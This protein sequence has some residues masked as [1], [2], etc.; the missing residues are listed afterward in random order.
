MALK[1][2]YNPFT[3]KFDCV[4]GNPFDYIKFNLDA[5]YEVGTG[6]MAWNADEHTLEFGMDGGVV[7]Q[8]GHE[9]FY[10]ISVNQTGSDI[11]EGAFVQF[12]GTLGNSGKLLIAPRVSDGS[13]PV[14]FSMGVVTN[15]GGIADGD[16]GHVTWFG[17]VRGLDTTGTYLT[18][19]DSIDEVNF[20]T[21][22]DGS[23]LYPNPAWDGHFTI[24]RPNA[25]NDKSPIAAVIH[26]HT[27][28]TILVRPHLIPKF[29]DLSDVNGTPVVTTG[30]LPVW[31]QVGK[32]FDFNY[33]ILDYQLKDDFTE[34]SVLFRGA[35]E[36]DEDNSN[37]FWD[38]IN[39]R[40]GIGTNTPQQLFHTYKNTNGPNL[41]LFENPNIGVAAFAGM[42]LKTDGGSSYIYRTSDAYAGG[43]E[44]SLVI[45]DAGNGGG[46]VFFVGN[47]RMRIIP[48]GNIGINKSTLA[49][50]AQLDI[51]NRF[52]SQPGLRLK[53]AIS[54]SA[55]LQ[56]NIKSDDTLYSGI[57]NIGERFNFDNVKN[58]F[59]TG[60]DASFHY[61]GTDLIVDPKEVSTGILSVLGAIG[62]E[63]LSTDPVDPA[64]GKSVI[65]QSD[66]TTT[67]DDG[68]ILIKE[69]SGGVVEQIS[70]KYKDATPSS[71][72]LNTGTHISGTV[73]DTQTMFD[74]NVY[75]VDEVTGVPGF[76]IE[77][78]FTGVDRVP[79]FIVARWI[80]DGSSTHFCTWDIYNYTTSTWDQVRMFKT[81]EAYFASMTMYIPR[82]SNGDYVDGGGNA[83]LRVYHHTSGNASHDMQIDY[84]G[85]THSLQ[86][87]I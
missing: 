18:L 70:L 39:K 72:T 4:E 62:I 46:I 82:A 52:T 21:W 16:E 37:F 12:A 54:Q 81:S 22:F 71:I 76:D 30:Q 53:G 59:G 31:D 19:Q 55:N 7:Q 61:N 73:A 17:K 63:E 40:L 56:E 50:T 69:Q 6:E 41:L 64:E 36:I 79:T 38:N 42:Q 47:E 43:I 32:Y 44:D 66:G 8:I 85:L 86:G 65:W 49:P 20:Q 51:V 14:E 29:T 33:N 25:P 10:P 27:N 78:N 23:I 15:T 34:G 74:G 87:V 11:P 60:S 5:G 1:F 9:S 83:K 84:V 68:D 26:A 13:V 3:N 77:F 58:W 80:Y 75:H 45:Q 35:T 2:K 67:G 57:N 48:N 28:G 24:I